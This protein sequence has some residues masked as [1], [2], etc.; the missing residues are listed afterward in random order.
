MSA[1]GRPAFLGHSAEMPNPQC[2][3]VRVPSPELPHFSLLKVWITPTYC[4]VP[5]EHA[6]SFGY[7]QIWHVCFGRAD[8]LPAAAESTPWL[9]L[10]GKA[11]RD[12]S[13]PPWPHHRK[14]QLTCR[15]REH[16]PAPAAS[17]TP[18]APSSARMTCSSLI[19]PLWSS[20][21]SGSC[22]PGQ[23]HSLAMEFSCSQ[24]WSLLRTTC[25][26][27]ALVLQQV[28]VE[29]SALAGN[30]IWQR[31]SSCCKFRND[32]CPVWLVI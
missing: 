14:P 12:R 18:A 20:P 21:A 25:N 30:L 19:P 32:S 13:K 5:R 6:E 29:L 31:F 27:R 7:C 10:A 24:R 1:W 2:R 11:A 17:L 28:Q 22:R 26:Q 8:L 3:V 4:T 16:L 23:C 15:A 9:F